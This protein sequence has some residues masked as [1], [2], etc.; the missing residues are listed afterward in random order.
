[1]TEKV[2]EKIDVVT[3]YR[4]IGSVVQPFKIRWR[5]REYIIKK[6]GYHHREKIGRTFFHIF[7]VSTEVLAFRLRMDPDTLGWTLEEVS[8]DGATN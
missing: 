1:M 8:D 2:D 3:I 6:L 5:G 4:R 7:H